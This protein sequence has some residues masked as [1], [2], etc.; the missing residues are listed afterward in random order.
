MGAPSLQN[1]VKAHGEAARNPG[2]LQRRGQ[3]SAPQTIALRRVVGAFAGCI[4][5]LVE[6]N[7]LVSFLAA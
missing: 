1:R 3:K 4:V 7:S 2:K 6:P 5:G